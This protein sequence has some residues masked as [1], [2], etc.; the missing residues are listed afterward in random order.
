MQT[1]IKKLTTN[2]RLIKEHLTKYRDTFQAFR[3]LINNSIQADAKNI[4]KKI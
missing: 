4:E 1:A 3:E 2:S